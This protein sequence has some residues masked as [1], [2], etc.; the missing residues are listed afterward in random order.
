MNRQILRDTPY[1]T[2]L[3]E[4]RVG[5]ARIERLWVKDAAQEEIRFS[6]WK[7]LGNGDQM[8]ERPLDVPED[9]LLDLFRGGLSAG[10]FSEDFTRQL[11][12]LL[13]RHL[14]D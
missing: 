4:H 2:L 1:A 3:A 7:N 5:E 9:E 13:Q 11:T 6:W 10:V 12:G 8:M 14:S